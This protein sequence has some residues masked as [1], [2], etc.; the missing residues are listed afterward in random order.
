MFQGV[1][2]YVPRIAGWGRSW[3]FV[4]VFFFFFF[5]GSST[6][7]SAGDMWWAWVLHCLFVLCVFVLSPSS[8]HHVSKYLVR[9]IQ[10]SACR[11]KRKG[12]ENATQSHS[13]HQTLMSPF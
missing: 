12:K 6:R 4:F 8:P 5:S 3:G 13:M 11:K 10:L 2:F 1:G 7:P 9:S